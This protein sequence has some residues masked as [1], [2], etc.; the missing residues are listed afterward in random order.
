MGFFVLFDG[1]R[2]GRQKR[3]A[4]G[5]HREKS[6]PTPVKRKAQFSIEDDMND[7]V[8]DF[9]AGYD[10]VSLD[11]KKNRKRDDTL[12]D[13]HAMMISAEKRDLSSSDMDDSD[14]DDFSGLKMPE[15]SEDEEDLKRKKK[16]EEK[17]DSKFDEWGRLGG[18]HQ[19][20]IADESSDDETY[21]KAYNQ[22]EEARLLQKK[23]LQSLHGD[24]FDVEDFDKRSDSD[25]E[26]W[27]EAEQK[28]QFRKAA[29]SIENV[30]IGPLKDQSVSVERV[31]ANI[32][33][34]SESDKLKILENDSPEL[35]GLLKDYKLKYNE[36]KTSV[37]PLLAEV[38]KKNLLTADGISLLETKYHLLLN[39]CM[40][41]SFYMLL[42]TEG[43]SVQDHP[44]IAHLVKLRLLLE[45]INPLEQKLRYQIQKLLKSATDGVVDA[46]DEESLK[47][48]PTLATLSDSDDEDTDGR[49][50]L[51]KVAPVEYDLDNKKEKK[52]KKK[53]KT[54]TSMAEFIQE[55]FADTPAEISY[56]GKPASALQDQVEVDFEED[57][58]V[59]LARFAKNR[60]KKE[61][62]VLQRSQLDDPLDFRDISAFDNLSDDEGKSKKSSIS[63]ILARNEER[64]TQS[65]EVD[66]PYASFE[67]KL[68][69]KR[70]LDDF[71]ADEASSESEIEDDLVEDDY[72]EQVKQAKKKRKTE[73]QQRPTTY[74]DDTLG[75]DEK[76]GLN[77]TISANRG[78]TRSRPKKMRNPRVRYR[79][80]AEQAEKK[81]KKIS[82]GFKEKSATYQGEQTGI[83]K[84]AKRSVNLK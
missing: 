39:Y 23:Q 78:L 59:R 7:E 36:L 82:R 69:N 60:H 44:V 21:E 72:Y 49:Y 45:K 14:S 34:L 81:F 42:K 18:K 46:P 70:K 3:L 12:Y 64:V 83:K 15:D 57:H 5:K 61:K 22:E 71:Q 58:F 30:S 33:K 25:D 53:V 54:N 63:D 8:D 38:T 35:L 48:K 29:K 76:R 41:I 67:R 37:Q 2:M 19:Y 84:S 52:R 75:D 40:N 11:V 10:E 79:T 17:L 74:R 20:H 31:K 66:I 9:M 1:Q 50:K 51:K 68:P 65:T 56:S 13:Q 4:R 62:E 26:Y 24:D 27:D 6:T 55:E 47:H 77:F 32:S 73:S 16:K 28:E 43:E 80:K